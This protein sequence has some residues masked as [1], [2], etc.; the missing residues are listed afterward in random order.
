MA[1]PIF[2]VV[3]FVVFPV[4]VQKNPAGSPLLVIGIIGSILCVPIGGLII[5]AVL[6][7]LAELLIQ[8]VFGDVDNSCLTTLVLVPVRL[9]LF[10]FLL[11][12]PFQGLFKILALLKH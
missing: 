10:I 3:G 2:C 6:M 5:A 12:L 11:S 1:F 8:R 9:G 4:I 7:V